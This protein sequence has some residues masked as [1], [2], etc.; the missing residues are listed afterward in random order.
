MTKVII[1]GC[2]GKMGQVVTDLCNANAEIQVV[3]GF[4]V[5]PEKRND[6]PVYADPMEF[7]GS[8]D[9]IIDFSHPNALTG[10]LSYCKKSGCGIVLATTGYSEAQLA[11]I[12]A[13]SKEIR[14]F[15]SANMSLGI[16]VLLALVRQAAKVLGSTSDIEIVEKH[17]N[18][19]LDAPSG[20]ALM[21]ADAAASALPYE[22]DYTFERHSVRQKRGQ[23]EIGISSVRGGTIVGEH[24]I[25]F[26]G[27]DEV[28]EIKHTAY[29]RDIFA[30][31]AVKA[32]AYIG[33]LSAPGLYNME[34]LV[35][36]VL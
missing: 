16:N 13:A 26:A 28:L 33:A 24:E 14:I 30:T 32:A 6:Y 36:E 23:T 9:C 21:I 1:S 34:N 5:N 4:D 15:K 22:P 12:Q 11:E 31:G 3:A 2:N 29:S 19:K 10:L 18:R 7:P 20:T 35:S 27:T 17:H 8:A 25:L